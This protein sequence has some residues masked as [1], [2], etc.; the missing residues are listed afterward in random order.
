MRFCGYNK[1]YIARTSVLMTVKERPSYKDGYFF[2]HFLLKCGI[3]W[4]V[5]V[6]YI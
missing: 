1:E 5:V 2:V 4:G 6:E 3:K